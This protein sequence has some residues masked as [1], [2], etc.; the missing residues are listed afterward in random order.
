MSLG[1]SLVR[2]QNL[3]SSILQLTLSS[4]CLSPSGWCINK[5]EGEKVTQLAS[6]EPSLTRKAQLKGTEEGECF[7][8]HVHAISDSQLDSLAQGICCGSLGSPESSGWK[9]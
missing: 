8:G 6:T 4:L 3:L 5:R 2:D 9:Q 1:T 7:A